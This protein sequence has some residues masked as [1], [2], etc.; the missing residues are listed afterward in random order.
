MKLATLVKDSKVLDWQTLGRDKE[1]V[2]EIQNRL[3]EIGFL[4]ESK[5]DGNFDTLTKTAI[6][7]FSQTVSLDNG[8]TGL[9]GPTFAKK[10]IEFKPPGKTGSTGALEIALKFTLQWE[11]G[12]VNN[13]IDLGGPTNKGITQTTYDSYRSRN[14]LP[15]KSVEFIT[16]VEVYEIYSQDYWKPSHAELMETPLAVV[17]FDTAVMFG[18]Q[19]A[20]QFLQESLGVHDD[21]IFGTQTEM[22]LQSS[23]NQDTALQMIAGRINYHKKMVEKMPEQEVFLEGWLNRAYDL[24]EFILNL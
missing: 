13:P 15:Y 22:A 11:G 19:G 8:K 3:R 9:F 4:K 6:I 5:L 24:R 21:G 1:L 23:K 16:D 18:V 10:L 12:Y 2:S 17:Q 20:I 14:S 7:G